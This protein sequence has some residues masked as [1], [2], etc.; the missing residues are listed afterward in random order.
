MFLIIKPLDEVKAIANEASQSL[1]SLIIVFAISSILILVFLIFIIKVLILSPLYKLSSVSD[2]ISEDIAQGKGDLTKRLVQVTEDEIGNT[3]HSFNMFIEKIQSMFLEIIFSSRKTYDDINNANESLLVINT[4]MEAERK[5]ISQ[6]TDLNTK[7]K[8]T[9]ENSLIDSAQAREKVDSAVE[10]LSNISGDISSL[11]EFADDV[12][13]KENNIASS[14]SE[15]SK[16][17]NDVKSVLNVIEDIA[18]QTNLLAL[19][20]AIEAARAGEH[21]RGF[22]VV[23]DE[24]RKLAERTQHSLAD[25]KATINVIVQSINDASSQIDI[26][27]KSVAK[28]VEHTSSVKDQVIESSTQIKEASDITKNSEKISQALAQDTEHII[29]TMNSVEKI[30]VENKNSLEDI[31]RNIRQVQSSA[32]DLN[33]QLNL[34]KVE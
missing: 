18:D 8:I 21:G 20:A 22:A 34:F 26:N 7:M 3:S 16:E 28:L 13:Q 1:V 6:T 31:S 30:S 2:E 24:V 5:L 32:N 33:N 25:I 11:V 23:A 19:N 10:T 17:A 4:R 29:D 9:I 14:L 27:A 15:L 12:S